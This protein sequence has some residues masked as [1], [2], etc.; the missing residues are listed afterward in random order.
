MEKISSLVKENLPFLLTYLLFVV[1]GAFILIFTHKGD[2]L[3]LINHY[4]IWYLDLLYKYLTYLGEGYYF[5]AI[6]LVMG[7]YRVKYLVQGVVLFV[8]SGLFTQLLK[9]IFDMPRPIKYFDSSV[10]L[11]LVD[12]VSVHSYN[13]FPS[14]HS[15]STF[16]IFLFFSIMVSNKLLKFIFSIIA[17]NVAISRV[18]LV[19]HFFIDIYVGSIIGVLFTL[20]IYVY[21]ENVSTLTKS[22][23]YN[24]QIIKPNL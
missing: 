13:S 14:G 2:F 22:K 9:H 19:Q 21:M 4:H 7:L 6:I 18:Y 11:N 1:I 5:L 3:L 20:I 16:T 24:Y 15:T 17:I 10:V 23:W 12:G 8:C